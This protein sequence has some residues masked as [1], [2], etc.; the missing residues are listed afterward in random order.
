M[1]FLN[2]LCIR[3]EVYVRVCVNKHKHSE[4]TKCVI[5]WYITNS[6]AIAGLQNQ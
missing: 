3:I 5:Q 2:L 6:L 1:L 4:P